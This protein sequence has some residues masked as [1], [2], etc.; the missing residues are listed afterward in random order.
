MLKSNLAGA[1]A[2]LLKN[3]SKLNTVC[4][5]QVRQILGLGPDFKP[6]AGLK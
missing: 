2:Q 1:K 3:A 5:C 4:T 6:K